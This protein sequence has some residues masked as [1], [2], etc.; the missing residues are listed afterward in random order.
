MPPMLLAKEKSDQEGRV[1]PPA[2]L[3]SGIR[4][5]ITNEMTDA[6]SIT[7]SV[8]CTHTDGRRPRIEIQSST[9]MMAAAMSQVTGLGN[10]E[11]GD[12]TNSREAPA[13]GMFPML[14]RGDPS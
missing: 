3:A 6:Y 11:L 4:A 1:A 5:R 7:I 10:V 14:K 13:R 2:W 8:V 12:T 9:P